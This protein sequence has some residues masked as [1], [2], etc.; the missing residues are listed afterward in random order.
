MHQNEATNI[1]FDLM[2]EFAKR[3]PAE[4]LEKYARQHVLAPAQLERLGNV[5]NTASTLVQM[6]KNKTA[7]PNLIDV[8]IM[9]GRYLKNFKAAHPV[10]FLDAPEQQEKAASHAAPVAFPDF[11]KPAKPRTEQPDPPSKNIFKTA[12]RE[13]KLGMQALQEG[14][15]QAMVGWSEYTD[16]VSGLARKAASDRDPGLFIDTL[17]H[18]L[19]GL[20]NVQAADTICDRVLDQVKASGVKIGE[21]KAS[22]SPVS[23]DRTGSAGDAIT[24]WEKLAQVVE[25]WE[26]VSVGATAVNKHKQAKRND[27][28]FMQRFKNLSQRIE[29]A[30]LAMGLVKE[31]EA[32]KKLED[33]PPRSF[34]SAI[35]ADADEA[36][37]AGKEPKALALRMGGAGSA[38]LDTGRASF[39]AISHDVPRILRE[40]TVDGEAAKFLD[41]LV[42][43]DN[44]DK[45]RSDSLD[46][47]RVEEDVRAMANVQKL[48]LTDEILSTKDP[49]IVMEAFHTI[50]RASPEV[51]SDSSLLRLMLRQATET[52]GVDIDTAS[53][54]RKYEFGGYRGTGSPTWGSSL[55]E[56]PP[57]N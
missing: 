16:I 21:S 32:A 7:A 25:G 38:V 31:S 51:A 13:L 41:D 34:T 36:S 17:R 23:R 37:D 42:G 44:R 2:P 19:N 30:A 22:A 49:E 43:K 14:V 24:A 29:K 8:P 54:G 50:R 45:A 18:D 56:S 5:F 15:N 26:A 11:W 4:V 53:A 52:Q 6:E 48:M 1:V 55:H 10:S 12:S 39:G 27:L 20:V 9:V 47:R 28:E 3:D 57:R 35:M 40:F 33:R 46:L